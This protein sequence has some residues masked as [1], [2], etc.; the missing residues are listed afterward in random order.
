MVRW[1]QKQT[2]L[3][4]HCLFWDRDGD[5]QIFPWDTYVGFRELGF[6]IIFSMLA[7]AIIHT[8]FSYPT[9]LGRSYVPDPLFR[10]YLDSIHKA[11]VS[12]RKAHKYLP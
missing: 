9:R 4:Q 5:G 3:Q 7:M 6:N 1:W 12:S 10:V 8:G 2:V 11:K